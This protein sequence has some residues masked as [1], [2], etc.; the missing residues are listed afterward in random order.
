MYIY[1]ETKVT[2]IKRPKYKRE[3]PT[4]YFSTEQKAQHKKDRESD[5]YWKNEQKEQKAFQTDLK[6]K[7]RHELEVLKFMLKTDVF[8]H[9]HNRVDSRKVEIIAAITKVKDKNIYQEYHPYVW[10]RYGE[11]KNY[12]S[13]CLFSNL[14]SSSEFDT[15]YD[16]PLDGSYIFYSYDSGERGLGSF[17]R[18][19]A[20]KVEQETR[21]PFVN[22]GALIPI[23]VN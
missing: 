6:K 9:H 16:V 8:D 18:M 19:S 10:N 23:T 5:R 4:G 2:R 20:K 7:I 22:P 1:S 13:I 3:Y 21:V 17:G 15:I 12:M 11:G 14:W